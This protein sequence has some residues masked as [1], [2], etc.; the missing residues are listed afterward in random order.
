LPYEC[1]EADALIELGGFGRVSAIAC[2][3]D[4]IAVVYEW[5]KR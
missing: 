2:H 4:V 5:Q 3:G 1:R